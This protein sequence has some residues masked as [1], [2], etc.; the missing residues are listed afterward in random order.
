MI[1]RI[2][3][4]L[5]P[6]VFED[7]EQ[8]R[9][10]SP[11]NAI[12]LTVLMATVGL[13]IWQLVF[14]GLPVIYEEWFTILGNMVI[15]V[16]SVGLLFFL[17]RGYVRVTGVVLSSALWG[18]IT[19]WIFSSD[20]IHNTIV[21]SYFLVIAIAGLIL[22][23]RAVIIFGLAC[24][25]AVAGVAWA[26]NNNF[27]PAT[28]KRLHSFELLM[29]IV[30]LGLTTLLLHFSARSTAEAFERARYNERALA[31]SNRDL[32]REIAERVQ[33]EEHIT[34][35]LRE[36]EVLLKEIHHRVK[37]NLSIVSSLLEF[38]SETVQ[39]GQF[40]AAFQE[41]QNRIHS[42]ARIHEHLYRSHD[43]ARVDMAEY[44]QGLIDYL[45][46]S[47]G[48][49][50]VALQIDI[51][52]IVLDI[53]RAIPCGLIINELVSN[54]LKHAFPPNWEGTEKVRVALHLDDGQCHLIVSDNGAGLPVDF[55]LENASHVSLGLRL[56]NL[57]TRQIKGTL[58][59][60]REGGTTFRLAFPI[61]KRK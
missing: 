52:D 37:N 6:P 16:L 35:S 11:L 60:N 47:Y 5:A 23:R 33:A 10:A 46:Q 22:G 4:L 40:R 38:Q 59:A 3:Q 51:L 58:Q 55:E 1:T 34:A 50:T 15:V 39:N 2:R 30:L 14:Y 26:Q 29:L 25:L 9:V 41:S 61:P 7:E 27:F 44:I 31:E 21:A 18:A 48:T 17:R 56:V 54:A 12:L 32:Q 45:N 24:I 53:D 28:A 43:L 13:S 36:K 20:G 19:L 57:L 42:M 8:T 49:Y